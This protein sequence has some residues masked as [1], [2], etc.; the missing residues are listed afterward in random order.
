MRLVLSLILAM[1]FLYHQ[2][3]QA[4]SDYEPPLKNEIGFNLLYFV[5]SSLTSSPYRIAEVHFKRSIGKQAIRTSFYYHGYENFVLTNGP[6]NDSTRQYSYYQ[7]AEKELGMKVGMEWKRP[8]IPKINFFF[9]FDVIGSIRTSREEMLEYTF[10][11]TG[12]QFPLRSILLQYA[13][14]TYS[15]KL[16]L[17]PLVGIQAPLGK[18]F[19][20]SFQTQPILFVQKETRKIYSGRILQVS[21]ENDSF[22]LA[23]TPFINNISLNVHF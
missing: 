5:S 17:G 8:L 23:Y 21:E 19:S 1:L 18:K 16:G 10:T 6:V 3:S 14:V 12:S 13:A 4:Q 7:F 22:E 9:G 11:Y 2:P 20:L 15:Q